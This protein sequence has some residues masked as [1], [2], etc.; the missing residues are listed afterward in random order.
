MFFFFTSV[1]Q[2][3][4]LKLELEQE[5]LEFEVCNYDWFFCMEIPCEHSYV[6]TAEEVNSDLKQNL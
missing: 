2:F 1:V 5:H 3:I 6:M 4:F